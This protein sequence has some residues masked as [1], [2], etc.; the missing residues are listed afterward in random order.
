MNATHELSDHLE[1]SEH[2]ANVSQLAG[3]IASLPKNASTTHYGPDG[4]TVAAYSKTDYA[5]LKLSPEGAVQGG[6][7]SHTSTDTDGRPI[8]SSTLTFTNGKVAS[9]KTDIHNRFASGVAKQ[10]EADF[11]NVRWTPAST[12]HSGQVKFSSRRGDTQRLRSD[13]VVTYDNEQIAT[14]AFRHYSPEGQGGV[15]GYTDIDYSQTKFIGDRI[16]GGYFSVSSKNAARA[17]NAQSHVFMTSTGAI[18]Q[19]HTKNFDPATAQLKSQVLTEFKNTQFNARNK[20]SG[21]E[22]H[23]SVSDSNNVIQSKTVVS[24]QNGVPSNAVTQN[25]VDAKLHSKVVSSYEGA[26][27]DNEL[28]AINS[29]VHTRGYDANEKLT[30]MTDSTYDS[31]GAPSK[32]QSRTLDPDTQT[33]LFLTETDYANTVFNYRRKP[34]G[35]HAKITTT[36]LQ[37]SSTVETV[38]NFT[39]PTAVNAAIEASEL[40]AASAQ[41]STPQY[42]THTSTMK[43]ADGQT[44]A[45]KKTIARSD[46]SP[47]KTVITNLADG[48]PTTVTVTLYAADGK[49]IGKTYSIDV[50]G[51]DAGSG[52]V[53]GTMKISTKFRGRTLSSE[54]TLEF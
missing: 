53:S 25:Y 1:A 24:Y 4:Q 14:G 8:N 49:T 10:V 7:L 47:L 16:T 2:I 17:E 28:R 9:A 32:T 23:Y 12:I 19:I 3:E 45:Y 54:S 37:D 20:I 30:S 34:I 40:L 5:N 44:T 48:K 46:G 15:E 33:P 11:T 51:V 41:A 27:F 36:N 31:H 42:A 21:G 13:G 38:K 39:S 35:G 26:A 22:A 18:D 50:S 29:T 52:K 43:N 6:T